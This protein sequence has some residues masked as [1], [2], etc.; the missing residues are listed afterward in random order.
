MLMFLEEGGASLAVPVEVERG[1]LFERLRKD[2]SLS[3]LLSCGNSFV[4]PFF[5]GVI[6]LSGTEVGNGEITSKGS[7]RV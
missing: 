2:L 1:M 7:V 5:T 4:F 6:S 3:L